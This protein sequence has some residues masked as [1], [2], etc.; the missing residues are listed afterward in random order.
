DT[1]S[2]LIASDVAGTPGFAAKRGSSLAV[3]HRFGTTGIT[4]SG[5]TGNAWQEVRT[6]PIG[7]RYRLGTF[8]ID[9]AFGRNWL[10]LGLSRLDEEQTL[11]GGKMSSLLGGGGSTTTFIDVE[12]RHNFGRGWT[13]TLAGRR[14]WTHFAGGKI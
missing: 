14:G 12:A 11:L 5:E 9:Q 4:F 6:N 8:A 1:G 13:S 3:R 2:F 10:S 7:S